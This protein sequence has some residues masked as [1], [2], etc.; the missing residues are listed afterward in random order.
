MDWSIF[1][2]FLTFSLYFPRK[3]DRIKVKREEG[4][5]K[6]PSSRRKEIM[7]VTHVDGITGAV[8][9]V[10]TK[11]GNPG[12]VPPWLQNG[13]GGIVPPWM[14]APLHILPFPFPQEPKMGAELIGIVP[15]DPNTPVIM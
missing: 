15:V 4:L 3:Y 10:H 2:V 1:S 8:R 13:N 11:N 6:K 5:T 12:I 9:T 14:N 7:I